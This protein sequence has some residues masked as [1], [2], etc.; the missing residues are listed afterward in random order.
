MKN[1]L[2]PT[3]FSDS[4]WD[5]LQYGVKLFED[6]ECTF[7]LLNVYTP[8]LFQSVEGIPATIG[9]EDASEVFS[10]NELQK[11]E[12]KIR[13]EYPNSKHQYELIT[14]YDY[15]VEATKDIVKKEDIDLIIMGTKGASGAQEVF[16]GSNTVRVIKSIKGCPI[17][18]IPK[19]S[20]F[21]L[22]SEIAFATDFKRFYS[23]IELQ[24]LIDLAKSFSA[25][26]RITYVD[27]H[28][29]ELT[30]EQ[31]FNLNMLD[32]YLKEVDHYLYTLTSNESIA[33][34]LQ[35]FTE[36]L[37]IYLLAMLHYKHS[38][39]EKLTREPIVKKLAFHIHIPF[40]VIPELGM[41]STFSKKTKTDSESEK[42]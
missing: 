2:I 1:I 35:V 11:L 9:M 27:Q 41:S 33:N 14:S 3:D 37:E 39:I 30:D 26:I 8:A 23:Y 42:I 17:L 38:F 19:G 20:D 18:V 22:P 28:Q 31:R 4:A 21:V 29:G 40:L 25:T 16:L 15:L 5:A 36:E 32:K 6:Q 12:S 10:M 7:F 24:P 13:E 34:S